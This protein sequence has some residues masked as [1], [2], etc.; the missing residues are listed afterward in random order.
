M[1]TF[2][3]WQGAV[4]VVDLDGV[5]GVSGSEVLLHVGVWAF[6]GLAAFGAIHVVVDCRPVAFVHLSLVQR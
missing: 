5:S 3:V 4:L 1:G 6:D 2:G